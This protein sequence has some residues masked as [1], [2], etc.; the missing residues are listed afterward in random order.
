MFF[1][2]KVILSGVIIAF[3]S[4]LAG[5][6]P[7]LAG[8]V[9]ALPLMSILS[10][11]FSYYQYRDM[12]KINEFAVSIFTAVPVSLFFFV[13][14]LLNKWVKMGFGATYALA[15]GCLAAAFFLH[16]L[17]LRLFF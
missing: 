8:F 4:W 2:L 9:I 17:L 7:V 1:A 6:N 3:A 13:P 12:N 10:I 15:L 5:R 11:A 14:F 16:K